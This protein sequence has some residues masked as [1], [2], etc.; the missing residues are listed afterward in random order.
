MGPDTA[1]L[2]AADRAHVSF[3]HAS[4][5][6][7]THGSSRH[8]L[9]LR[10]PTQRDRSRTR[11]TWGAGRKDVYRPTQNT[12]DIKVSHAHIEGQRVAGRQAWRCGW[13]C[14]AGD[15]KKRKKK[16]RT[17]R[18]GTRPRRP[19]DRRQV[20]EG[21]RKTWEIMAHDIWQGKGHTHTHTLS[22]TSF[23]NEDLQPTEIG[24]GNLLTL[25]LASHPDREISTPACSRSPVARRP[26]RG[27]GSRLA[28][29]RCCRPRRA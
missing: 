3:S 20:R 5:R 16:Q 9:H 8:S 21:A 19:R 17:K 28:R 11:A 7:A 6:A 22:A 24:S 13:V 18:A 26:R 4:P 10:S 15:K 23:S 2:R 29:G 12:R 14:F 1:D 27:R 25:W